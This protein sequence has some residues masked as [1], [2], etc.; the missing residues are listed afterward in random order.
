MKPGNSR[1]VI[2]DMQGQKVKVFPSRI[3]GRGM[4]ACVCEALN[5]QTGQKLACK[6]F[7]WYEAQHDPC[8]LEINNEIE[9][10]Q[11]LAGCEN[12][13]RYAG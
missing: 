11:L 10:L 2:I 3:L 1:E 4:Q 8:K 7:N 5:V 12:V 6:M 9:T 13:A